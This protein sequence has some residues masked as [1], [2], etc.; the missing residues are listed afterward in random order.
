[1]LIPV[2]T[3]LNLNVSRHRNEERA[4]Y[5]TNEKNMNKRKMNET[6]MGKVKNQ[7]RASNFKING[8]IR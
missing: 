5:N 8:C 7:K 4:H 2:S 1:M 3:W 6:L